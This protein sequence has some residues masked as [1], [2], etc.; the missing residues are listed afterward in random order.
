MTTDQALAM[1][2]ADA[3]KLLRQ[4]RMPLPLGLSERE[5]DVVRL[6][7]LGLTDAA[8]AERL[9]LSPRTVQGHLRSVY[10]KLGVKNRSAAV[11][12]ATQAGLLKRA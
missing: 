5:M 11:H 7:A 10:S 6:L 1:A 12:Q 9:V 3:D 8:I 2:A 4:A